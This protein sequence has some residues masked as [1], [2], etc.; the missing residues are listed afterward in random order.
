MSQTLLAKLYSSG[1]KTIGKDPVTAYAWLEFCA[2]RPAP[3]TRSRAPRRKCI[4]QLRGSLDATSWAR[5][6]ENGDELQA[7][8]WEAKYRS[9]A[10]SSLP[11]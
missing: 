1:G 6:A 2:R 7:E 8:V 3:I 4:P 5:R 10:A 9:F 11:D